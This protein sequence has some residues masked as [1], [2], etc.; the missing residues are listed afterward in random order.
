MS[1]ESQ[2]NPFPN[3]KQAQKLKLLQ[4]RA[5]M[6]R[7]A[8]DFFYQREVMEVDCPA[9]STSPSVDAYIDLLPAFYLNDQKRYLHSSPEYGMKRLLSQNVGDCFQLSHVFRD[10]EEGQLHNPEFMMAEWYRLDFKLE[11]MIQETID[12]CSLFVGK[13]P[14]KTLSFRQALLKFADVD[15]LDSSIDSL[16]KSLKKF[17]L[18]FEASPQTL[19]K[20][21]LLNL[22]FSHVVEPQLVNDSFWVITEYPAHQAALAEVQ[23]NE[24]Q[25]YVALRFELFFQGLELANGYQE[26]TDFTEH[27]NRFRQSNE[28]RVL[29]GKEQLSACKYFLKALES[30]LPESC[31]VAVG[32]DR[33][34]MLRH[35]AKHIR[36][37]LSFS[38]D[39]I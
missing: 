19:D 9:L 2:T 37:V 16:K 13:K 1:L 14:V 6:L 24:S 27:K 15:Y 10:G 12:F 36:E 4:D 3:P 33:L 38:W 32:F 35:Q 7:R 34:M 39:E 17:S 26:L 18:S 23:K 25:E 11:E 29:N 28:K 21:I 5:Q 22:L 30:G 31:G 20:E 8:R